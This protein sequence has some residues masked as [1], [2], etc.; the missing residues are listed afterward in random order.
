MSE[1]LRERACWLLLVYESKLSVRIVNDILVIW[2]KQLG[3]TLQEFFAASAQEWDVICHLKADIVQKLEETREKLVG[4]IFLA[5]QLQHAHIHM[6]TVLDP[7]YPRT[8]K[9]ALSRN[10]IPPLLFY[11]GNLDILTRQTIA[12]IGSRNAHD[13]SL[14]FT[15]EAARYLS[16]HGA[17][18]I[19]GYARGVDR[20][21]YEGAM[22]S[23]GCTTIVLPQGIRKLSKARCES[24][25]R[26]RRWVLL[27]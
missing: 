18:V 10:H 26:R 2:C 23:E 8:L 11:M 21:A 24:C 16:A 15:R 14:T 19:S 25:R 17:N 1:D 9:S 6:M 7:V 13:A 22:S 12:L 4:Q 27:Y 20:A 3:R 5:E